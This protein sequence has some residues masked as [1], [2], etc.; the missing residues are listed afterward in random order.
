MQMASDQEIEEVHSPP[1]DMDYSATCLAEV[2]DKLRKAVIGS[3][4]LILQNAIDT[5]GLE[6]D[7][8]LCRM[9]PTKDVREPLK[10]DIQ[11]LKA[12]FTR[13]YRRA[14]LCF[15]L[16]L[17]SFK[18]EESSVRESERASWSELWR[19]EDSEFEA[20]L[21]S[22]PALEKYSNRYFYVWDG[23]HRHKAWS[24]MINTLHKDD[25]SF[26][27]HVRSVIIN[28]TPANCNMLLHAMIDWN[29]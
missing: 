29:K 26:R 17:K 13:G 3:S 7:V 23:N 1:M 25:A 19:K 10:N 22:N 11:K 2:K 24:Q 21:L 5:P 18:M 6:I 14:S 4:H 27:V 15:Y 8:P 28:V 12:E 9:I 20:R 16:S